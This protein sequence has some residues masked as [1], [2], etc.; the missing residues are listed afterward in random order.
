LVVCPTS[1]KHQW[2]REVARFSGREAQIVSG[3]RAARMEHYAQP[4]FWK[5]TNYEKLSPD[6]EFIQAWS[7]D[8]VI[9][10][11]AQRIKN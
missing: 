5:V 2:Q 10:D 1:L 6:L 3:G 7:P 11:E 4:G 9:V 8:V